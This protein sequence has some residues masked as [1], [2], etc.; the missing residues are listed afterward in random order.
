MSDKIN[1]MQ[2]A[3]HCRKMAERAYQLPANAFQGG[4]RSPPITPRRWQGQRR[5]GR[6]RPRHLFAMMSA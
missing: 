6:L 4:V 1:F 3:A 5:L 2:K